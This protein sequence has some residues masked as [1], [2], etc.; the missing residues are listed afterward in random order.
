MGILSKAWSGLKNIFSGIGNFFKSALSS[1][2]IWKTIAVGAG[3]YFGGAALGYWDSGVMK[4][5]NGKWAD[6]AMGSEGTLGK[7][8]GVDSATKAKAAAKAAEAS[9]MVNTPMSGAQ[10]A[11]LNEVVDTKEF[12][13]RKEPKGM[14]ASPVKD[15]AGAIQSYELPDSLRGEEQG[16]LSSVWDSAANTAVGRG[17]GKVAD[18]ADR[19]PTAAAMGLSA[20]AG[21]MKRDPA[22]VA[23]EANIADREWVRNNFEVGTSANQKGGIGVLSP[24]SKEEVNAPMTAKEREDLNRKKQLEEELDAI[25]SRYNYA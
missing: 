12:G 20:V 9:K 23:A 22:E 17:I 21:A 8:L 18:M 7:W 15:T 14:F 13:V 11:D 25:N 24:Y 3:V 10:K 1:K 4:S 6:T 5:I 19:H 16:L 2:N